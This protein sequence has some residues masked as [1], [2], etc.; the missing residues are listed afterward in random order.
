MRFCYF[1]KRKAKMSKIANTKPAKIIQSDQA[2]SVVAISSE[3]AS[4]ENT[5]LKL[6]K[7]TSIKN[8]VTK[9]ELITPLIQLSFLALLLK[10]NA[11]GTQIKISP[12]IPLNVE[13]GTFKPPA[14]KRFVI[15][16]F[17]CSFNTSPAKR[18]IT[19]V[20]NLRRDKLKKIATAAAKININIT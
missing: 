4:R 13:T 16:S 20:P 7:I 15:G 10:T 6:G 2:S 19:K 18:V 3:I 17:Q 9:T 14:V 1:F 5:L 8:A 12:A 11:A